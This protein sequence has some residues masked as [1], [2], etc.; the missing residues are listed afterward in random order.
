MFKNSI[1][2]S[3]TNNLALDYSSVLTNISNFRRSNG[4]NSDIRFDTPQTYYF[5]LFFYF[6]NK[7]E[8]GASTTISGWPKSNLLGLDY[9]SGIF[10]GLPWL[11]GTVKDVDKLPSG[12]DHIPVN[13][14]LNYL[15]INYE[16]DRAK[17]LTEFI[18]LLS[19]ISCKYPW[20]F[21]TVSGVENAVTRKEAVEN[22]FK[23]E[24]QRRSIQIKCLPDS[25]NNKI[26]RLL[27]L[28]RNI[29]YS[30]SMHKYILPANLRKFDMGIFIF[31]RPIK[32]LHRGTT[33]KDLN[34]TVDKLEWD[35]PEITP[36][37]FAS[38]MPEFH[39]VGESYKTSYKYIEFH[40]CE[41]D[42]N[43]TASGYSELNNAEGFKQEYTINIFYDNA[44]E[45]R[46]D[47][48]TIQ[49]IGDYSLWDL[50]LS[51]LSTDDEDAW[52]K[53]HFDKINERANKQNQKREER[54][55]LLTSKGNTAKSLK[56]EVD[57]TRAADYFGIRAKDYTRNGNEEKVGE[58]WESK[59]VKDNPGF[60]NNALGQVTHTAYNEYVGSPM[61]KFAL[62]NFY[63]VQFRDTVN[64]ANQL[65]SGNIIGG[66]NQVANIKN[67]WTQ[68]S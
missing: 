13:T 24:D 14:A 50:N 37:D 48:W 9:D 68:K 62:G 40:N 38:F 32:N 57:L 33:K 59:L 20:Y 21:T 25:E 60:I 35:K 12:I 49:N 52:W 36:G 39:F 1:F 44:L 43:S 46:Y 23:L 63:A 31:S 10:N 41:I 58:F 61:K 53:N 2:R 3:A 17:K 16:W 6:D 29:V 56:D 19:E 45:N 22:D 66:A 47:E 11:G 34:P 51:T 18:K 28:Y 67:G 26:G 15:L 7:D 42:Y 54:A 64:A 30:Q 65:S 5:K 4:Y 55:N 8:G 27:D